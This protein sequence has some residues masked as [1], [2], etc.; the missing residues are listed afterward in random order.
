MMEV[1]F[2]VITDGDLMGTEPVDIPQLVDGDDL[3]SISQ[4]PRSSCGSFPTKVING[5]LFV[6]ASNDK[7]A[8]LES[9][10][11]PVTYRPADKEEGTWTGPWNYRELPYG[12][13]FFQENVVDPGKSFFFAFVGQ[14]V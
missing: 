1:F 4:N 6:W 9:E 10:F 7:D 5:V 12:H 3:K 11:T 2:V 14:V 8:V 13:D